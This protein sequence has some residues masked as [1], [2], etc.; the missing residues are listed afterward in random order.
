MCFTR[1]YPYAYTQVMVMK[2][3]KVSEGVLVVLN[4][5]FESSFYSFTF[6]TYASNYFVVGSSFN[7]SKWK[8]ERI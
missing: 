2:N 6:T 4:L 1:Q 7:N 8:K 5:F 3:E